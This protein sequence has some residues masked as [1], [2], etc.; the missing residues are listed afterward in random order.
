[1]SAKHPDQTLPFRLHLS[2]TVSLRSPIGRRRG[3]PARQLAFSSPTLATA[4]PSKHSGYCAPV[5]ASAREPHSETTYRFPL[6]RRAY[7]LNSV[8]MASRREFGVKSQSPIYFF[9]SDG[10]RGLAVAAVPH[11]PAR[12]PINCLCS[13]SNLFPPAWRGLLRPMS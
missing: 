4:Y 5:G 7:P 11:P 6:G 13:S 2:D 3:L 12:T 1:M 9:P 10:R 8:N